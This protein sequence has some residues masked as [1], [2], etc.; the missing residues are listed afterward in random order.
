[1][2]SI[3]KDQ[4]LQ[5][6]D[7]PQIMGIINLTPDSFYSPSRANTLEQALQQ[8]L[9][10]VEAGASILDLGGHSTRPGAEQISL[11]EELDRVIP[12][13]EAVKKALPETLISVDTYRLEVAKAAWQAGAHLWNDVG[14]GNLDAGIFEWL[15]QSHMPYVLSHS[16]G[17]YSAL[18]QVPDYGNVLEAVWMD[19][20]E[21][22]LALKA[23]GHH[24]VWMDPGF[25]FSKN[26]AQNYTLL[27]HLEQFKHWQR[28]LL[29]GLSR[30]SMIWKLLEI[31][32][33]ESL[34]ASSALHLLAF[35][36]GADV[37]RV[38]DVKEAKQVL[39]LYQTLQGHG[40]SNLA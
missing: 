26:I 28:P 34:P 3:P 20:N 10:M 32:P 38:H 16:R 27:A 7:G 21:K 14:A 4:G 1:M 35:M 2:W 39:Q 33:E 19:L 5:F 17:Q 36:K 22:F 12:I 31:S 40:L 29:V 18:H 23:L 8:A 15:A 9:A 11:Q 30:K 6:Y 24:E 37:L 13:L 25:G